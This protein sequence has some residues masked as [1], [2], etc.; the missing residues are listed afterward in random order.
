MY[1]RPLRDQSRAVG[2]DLRRPTR[3]GADG[4]GEFGD[5]ASVVERVAVPGERGDPG[6]IG[7]GGE[8]ALG[9]DDG[10]QLHPDARVDV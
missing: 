5:L 6:G 10:V 4:A 9:V 8:L 7:A 2:L 1:R 3:D